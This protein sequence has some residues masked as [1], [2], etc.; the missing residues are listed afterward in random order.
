MATKAQLMAELDLLKQQMASRDDIPS[1]DPDPAK[2]ETGTGSGGNAGDE[3]GEEAG[4][5]AKSYLGSLLASQ[6]ID[7]SEVEALWSQL[8]D[9]LGDLTRDKPLLTALTALGIGFALGR[10]SK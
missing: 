4:N 10:L 8:T 9:E 3:T 2:S 6:G 7:D 5:E 1:S